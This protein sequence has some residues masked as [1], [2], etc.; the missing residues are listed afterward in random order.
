MILKK[1]I[2]AGSIFFRVLS[3]PQFETVKKTLTFGGINWAIVPE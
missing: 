1:L 3:G 2:P